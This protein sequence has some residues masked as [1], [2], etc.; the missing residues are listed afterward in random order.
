MESFFF[1]TF[2]PLTCTLYQQT[3]LTKLE[4]LIKQV[5][6]TVPVQIPHLSALL[7]TTV[8]KKSDWWEN[9][10]R[11]SAGPISLCS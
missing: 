11:R 7:A 4:D 10:E 3:N 8:N 1:G 6:S 2:P 9:K 5:A